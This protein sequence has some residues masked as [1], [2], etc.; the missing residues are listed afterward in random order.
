MTDL[1]EATE[2]PE[3]QLVSDKEETNAI[4]EDA[5]SPDAEKQEVAT[6]EAL[7]DAPS[8]ETTGADPAETLSSDAPRQSLDNRQHP[9]FKLYWN[10]TVIPKSK[11]DKPII[12]SGQTCEI[13]KGGMSMLSEANLV[14]TSKMHATATLTIPSLKAGQL[15]KT[16]DIPCLI[17][18]SYLDNA[19]GKFRLGLDFMEMEQET[20]IVLEKSLATRLH[21]P[22]NMG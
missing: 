9:R 5:P 22:P 8:A 13:S 20:R 7:A 3:E 10:V 21:Y 17:V 6:E 18:H 16:I 11:G 14:V 12:I 2:L 19:F 15:S 1:K 4:H